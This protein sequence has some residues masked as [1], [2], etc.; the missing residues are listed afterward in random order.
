MWF[1][2]SFFLFL[3]LQQLQACTCPTDPLCDHWV[4]LIPHH[5]QG[6]GMRMQTCSSEGRFVSHR[7]PPRVMQQ[8]CNSVTVNP[9]SFQSHVTSFAALKAKSA[10]FSPTWNDVPFKTCDVHS[11]SGEERCGGR[12]RRCRLG[13][14]GGWDQFSWETSLALVRSMS[15]LPGSGET[16]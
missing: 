7:L 11:P 1:V 9:L 8:R 15:P 14:L 16:D 6:S 10:K 3:F 5:R 4:V 2:F 13:A 12:L